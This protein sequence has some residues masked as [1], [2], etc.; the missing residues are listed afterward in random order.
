MICDRVNI[1]TRAEATRVLKKGI[2]KGLISVQERN[3]WPQNVWSVTNA[4]EPLE[5]ELE[6]QEIGRY[7]GFPMA[8]ND[9]FRE[10]VIKRWSKA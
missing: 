4:G 1:L 7:H 3:G 6:N 2:R 9:P 5:A 10:D 8:L